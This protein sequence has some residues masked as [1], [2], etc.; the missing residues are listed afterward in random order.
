MIG[1][2]SNSEHHP[3]DTTS[4]L[5]LEMSRSPSP[6]SLPD[7]PRRQKNTLTDNAPMITGPTPSSNS[8]EQLSD[9]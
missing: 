6:I 7:T 9:T 2:F 3:S 5:S 8:Q 4:E 1:P